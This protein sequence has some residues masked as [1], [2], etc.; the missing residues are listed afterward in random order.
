MLLCLLFIVPNECARCLLNTCHFELSP[1]GGK[2]YKSDVGA[3]QS[4][5]PIYYLLSTNRVISN[6]RV[7]NSQNELQSHR[8]HAV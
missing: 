6:E 8:T 4:G 7:G 5:L 1:M 2:S 3:R